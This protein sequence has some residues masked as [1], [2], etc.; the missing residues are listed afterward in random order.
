MI[1]HESIEII[2]KKTVFFTPYPIINKAR[3]FSLQ[4]FDDIQIGYFSSY[5]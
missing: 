4:Y 1:V 5:S 2:D 3:C